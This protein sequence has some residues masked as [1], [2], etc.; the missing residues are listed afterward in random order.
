M[1]ELTLTTDATYS[2]QCGAFAFYSFQIVTLTATLTLDVDGVTD[3]IPVIFDKVGAQSG[4]N[5]TPYGNEGVDWYSTGRDDQV[6]VYMKQLD[7]LHGV[8]VL[9]VLVTGSVPVLDVSQAFTEAFIGSNDKPKYSSNQIQFRTLSIKSYVPS[10]VGVLDTSSVDQTPVSSSGNY[11]YYRVEV[12]ADG[13]DGDVPAFQGLPNMCVRLTAA[14]PDESSDFLERVLLYPSL[15]ATSLP[16]SYFPDDSRTPFVDLK[17]DENG[18]AE[19][20]ICARGGKD[21]CAAISCQTGEWASLIGPVLV[22][23]IDSSDTNL[24]APSCPNPLAL[25]GASTVEAI[26]P[27]GSDLQQGCKVFLFCNGRFQSVGQFS[28]Q[29]LQLPFQ[30][31]SLRSNSAPY[32]DVL[33]NKLYYVAAN[34]AGIRVS[35]TLSFYATGIPPAAAFEQPYPSASDTLLAAP[36]I[37]EATDGWPINCATIAN[38]LTIRVPINAQ[39]RLGGVVI[40]QMEMNGY[41]LASNEPIG[42]NLPQ[43]RDASNPSA[44]AFTAFDQSQG[45]IDWHYQPNYF[46]GFGQ[47]HSSDGAAGSLGTLGVRYIVKYDGEEAGYYSEILLIGLDTLPPDGQ[48]PLSAWDVTQA[49]DRE[50]QLAG[51]VKKE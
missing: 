18:L 27:P 11:L 14:S 26:I 19:L 43:P 32:S 41:H 1:A 4:L 44:L 47:L 3:K 24:L 50:P 34:S 49:G 33:P 48:Y 22:V 40:I 42:F 15:D 10:Y 29:Q 30:S 46:T 39:M 16:V 8:A 45:Y 23:D 2:K 36:E 51:R 31:A 28:G 37:R 38:G 25:T 21:A 12:T 17:T 7:S 13:K 5:L 6:Q 9:R 35:P 20:Y